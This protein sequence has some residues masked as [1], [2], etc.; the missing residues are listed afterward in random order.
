MEGM[1]EVAQQGRGAILLGILATVGPPILSFAAIMTIA[2]AVGRGMERSHI[3]RIVA[4]EGR[5]RSVT[6]STCAPPVAAREVAMV[7][8]S[9]VVANDLFKAWRARVRQ[10]FGGRIKAYESLAM[11]A[12]REAV[13]RMKHEAAQAG[14]DHICGVRLQTTSI[15]VGNQEGGVEILAYG[16]AVK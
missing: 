6:A 12:R 8:G 3:Q 7:S 1:V 2:W 11:R 15:S 9:V 16:T 5:L 10:I 14:Y 4:A 13:V